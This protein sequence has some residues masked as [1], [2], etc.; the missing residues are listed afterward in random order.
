[1]K[2]RVASR[3]SIM[4]FAKLLNQVSGAADSIRAESD[5]D[6]YGIS[7]GIVRTMRANPKFGQ[8]QR[9]RVGED[10]R[11]EVARLLRLSWLTEGQ[12]ALRS[13]HDRELLPEILLGSGPEA[14]YAVYHAT[15]AALVSMGQPL[16]KAHAKLLHQVENVA[17]RG[18]LPRALAGD[19]FGKSIVGTLWVIRQQLQYKD[20]NTF[21]DGVST[22]S[23]AELFLQSLRLIVEATVTAMNV[24][25]A[26]YLGPELVVATAR[27]L[28]A[29]GRDQIYSAMRPRM[30]AVASLSPSHSPKDL[31]HGD[32]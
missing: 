27:P 30:R 3:R 21:F 7:L 28:V 12:Q 25:A 2:A 17:L 26:Q 31:G 16:P 23:E 24:L 10:D 32:E 13:R 4:D 22:A 8:V 29:F 14:Y 11:K 19:Q 5:R 6:G 9:R 18:V 20:P 15:G 1:M